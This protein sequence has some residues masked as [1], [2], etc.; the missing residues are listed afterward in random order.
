MCKKCRLQHQFGVIA[1]S[2]RGDCK[3]YI[4]AGCKKNQWWQPDHRYCEEKMNNMSINWKV[5]EYLVRYIYI[6]RFATLLCNSCTVRGAHS[7]YYITNRYSGTVAWKKKKRIESI[8]S[9][10]FFVQLILRHGTQHNSRERQRKRG[11]ING[12]RSSQ[13]SSHQACRHPVHRAC[14]LGSGGGKCCSASAQPCI[15]SPWTANTKKIQKR[16]WETHTWLGAEKKTERKGSPDW[17]QCWGARR[18]NIP[19]ISKGRTCNRRGQLAWADRSSACSNAQNKGIC[20]WW[21]SGMQHLWLV[22]CCRPDG[23]EF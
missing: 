7:C 4:D 17:C 23:G 9:E 5:D 11:V 14:R 6:S 18:P 22:S 8:Y 20:Y 2:V 16:K 19:C 3:I 1:T 15:S 12:I 21:P 13:S 10:R